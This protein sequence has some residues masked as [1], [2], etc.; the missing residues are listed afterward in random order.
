MAGTGPLAVFRARVSDAIVPAVTNRSR[1]RFGGSLALAA[2]LASTLTALPAQ[3]ASSAGLTPGS[4]APSPGTTTSTMTLVTGDVVTSTVETG[5]ERTVSVRPAPRPSGVP[6]TFSTFADGDH[7]YVIPSDA[8]PYLASDALD[9]RLFDLTSL[10]G[11]NGVPPVIVQYAGRPAPP[12]L[13][14]SA[15]ALPGTTVTLESIGAVATS[16]AGVWS[17]LTGSARANR[18][19]AGVRKVWLDS[20][21]SASLDVSVPQIGAPQ[22]WAAGYDGTG[23]KVAILDTGLDQSH[24][25]M[26]GKVV[27]SQ[28]FSEEASTADGNGHGTHVASIVTG[29][30]A[31][32]GGT[33][34]GVAPGASLMIGKVLNDSGSGLMSWAIDGMEW[35]AHNG[36]DVVNLSLSAPATDGT[37]PGSLAVDALSAETGTLFV[38]A[39]GNDYSDA[40]VGTPGAATAAL[41]VGAVDDQDALADFSNRGPRRGDAAVKPNITA[42][43]VGIIAA[44]AAGTSLGSPLDDHYTSLSGTSMA[45]PHVAGAAALLAQAHPDWTGDRLKDALVSTAKPGSYT[46]YQQGAGRVDAAKAFA[47]RV[48]GPATADFGKVPDPSTEPAVRTLEYRNDTDAAVTLGLAVSG[49]GWDGRAVPATAAQ[50]SATTLTIP[51]NGTASADLTL[52]PAQLDGGVYSGVVAATGPAGITVRTPWSL[53]EAGDTHTLNTSLLDRRGRSAGVGAPIWVVKTDEGFNANDPFRSW[54]YFA[55]SDGD[56]AASFDLAPGVYDVYAQITT[57]ELTATESTVAIASEVRVGADTS[58]TLDA[59]EAKRRNP[60]VGEDVDLLMGE[61]G[62]IRH[63]PD[64]REFRIGALFDQSTEWQ[65]YTTPS[66]KPQLGW[67]ESYTKWVYGSSL[68]R[69]GDGLHPEYWPHAAGPALAGRRTLPVVYAGDNTEAELAAAKGKLALVRIPI[70][71]DEPF[72]YGYFLNELQRV[73]DIAAA[74]GVAGVIAYADTPGAQAHQVRAEPI[75]QLGLSRTEGEALRTSLERQPGKRL[76]V[77]GRLSPE[78]VYH[79]RLGYDGGYPA[80]GD[81]VIGK[82]ELASIPAVYHSDSPQ[83]E[84]Q[85]AWFAFSP[86]M[87]DSSQLTVPLWAPASWTELIASR[88]EPLR[89][90]RQTWLE[91]TALRIWDVFQPGERRTTETWFESPVSYGAL[92]VAGPYPTT[93]TCTF[94]RQGD[95]FASGQYRIDA[96]GRHYEFAWFDPPEVHLYGAD[97][98]EVPRQGSTWKWFQLAPGAATYRLTMRYTQPGSAPTA[99]ATRIDTEWVFRSEPPQAGTLQP[100]YTCPFAN[101]TSPCAADPLLQLRYDL[102]LSPANTAPA[103][104]WFGFDIAA[105]PLSGAVDQTPASAMQVWYSTDDGATWQPASVR[106]KGKDTF[107]VSLRNPRIEDG[108]GYVSLRFRASN[109]GGSVDQTVQRAYR[110][111]SR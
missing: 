92:D 69:V 106:R 107:G 25:D 49:S 77:D 1:P 60:Q 84:G 64:G 110:L 71:P 95:R 50:L 57:W 53:Y 39:S 33:Y 45:T 104:D 105:G 11:L 100:A 41:T 52:D 23:V 22:V 99:L 35:A 73:T 93:L 88:G 43:G 16:G 27:A 31:A 8:A 81:P 5:R 56:G 58:V 74:A 59:R 10:T 24:P 48:Y 108:T 102:G 90:T 7:F 101:N 47:Q 40:A 63:T 42:P 65:L 96:S 19:A 15:T 55:W 44:R 4:A 79:L 2:L 29:T 32:S 51:P 34:R 13:S 17:T 21:V 46:A 97:G 54:N 94:C 85:L 83:Q 28:N 12:T 98:T 36:A 70:P 26:A 68:V 66:A 18:L 111:E 103:D 91:D 38:I 14:R 72:G 78:R 67:A 3:P 9:R 87:P 82:Q 30:G 37:D 80:T 6:V 86:N 109:S 75:L 20:K 76:T 62:V 61:I 89:W